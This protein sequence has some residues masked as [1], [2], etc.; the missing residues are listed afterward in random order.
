MGLLLSAAAAAAC[1]PDA[2]VTPVLDNTTNQPPH[3][4]AQT[5][6]GWTPPAISPVFSFIP[7]LLQAMHSTDPPS[8]DQEVKE[9]TEEAHTTPPVPTQHAHIS[10]SDEE[11]VAG[12]G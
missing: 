3:T 7:T 10:F 4:H 9:D 8:A 12:L 11:E 1:V 5:Q 2:E 6:V